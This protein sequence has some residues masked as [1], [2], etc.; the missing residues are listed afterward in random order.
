M[1]SRTSIVDYVH[2]LA[3]TGNIAVLWASHLI[4]EIYPDDRLIVLHK[5]KIRA[6]GSVDEV[7]QTTGTK[8]IKD[9]FFRLTQGD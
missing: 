4:D 7:L 1:P 8:M 6:A 5:G 2:S 3:H 9:A